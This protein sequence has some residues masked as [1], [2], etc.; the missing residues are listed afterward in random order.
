MKPVI[1]DTGS[2]SSKSGFS[3]EDFPKSIIPSKVGTKKTKSPKE[4][5]YGQESFIG[6]EC[7]QVKDLKMIFPIESGIIIN[8]E[9][10]E[11][12]LNHIF[13]KELKVSPDE[14]PALFIEQHNNSK[15]SREKFASLMFETFEMPA[16]YLTPHSVLSLYSVGSN[17]GLVLDSSLQKS[18]AIPI[19]QS[20]AFSSD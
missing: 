7:L 4:I 6:Q 3:G 15:G 12:L 1:V 9:D 18:R 19:H 11:K 14:R 5:F 8:W 16:I 20:I 2:Y 10:Y 17:D 13:F